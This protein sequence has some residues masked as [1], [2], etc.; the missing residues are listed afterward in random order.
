ML[1]TFMQL[2]SRHARAMRTAPPGDA[3][4][5]VQS[6]RARLEILYRRAVLEPT[7]A[8]AYLA[9]AALDLA[10]LRAEVLRRAV[11]PNLPPAP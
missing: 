5:I 3:S 2:L 9:L 4:A 7:V 11:F 10:R 6:L 1:V 8:F